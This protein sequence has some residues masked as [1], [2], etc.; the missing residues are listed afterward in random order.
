MLLIGFS[1]LKLFPDVYVPLGTTLMQMVLPVVI[2]M[3]V[4]RLNTY[5]QQIV[6]TQL[7]LIHVN[8]ILDTENWGKNVLVGYTILVSHS[9]IY[10]THL[11]LTCT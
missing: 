7:D 1:Q 5:V 10:F 6:S 9:Y 3:N 11:I 8:V 4:Q 2:L